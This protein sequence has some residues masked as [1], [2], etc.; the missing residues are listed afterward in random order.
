MAGC[1]AL[2]C[3]GR[4]S[5]HRLFWAYTPDLPLPGLGILY[6]SFSFYEI[7]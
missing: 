2:G 5:A 4:S 1:P 6:L 7:E 3:R